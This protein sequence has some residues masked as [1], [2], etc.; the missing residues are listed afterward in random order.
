[1]NNKRRQPWRHLKRCGSV[2]QPT[3][4]TFTTRTRATK[5]ERSPKEL[6]LKTCRMTGSARYAGL[7]KRI[8]DPWAD[9]DPWQRKGTDETECV[10][11]V[12]GRIDE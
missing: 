9:P 11:E 7:R 8:L 12:K 2:R 4:D 1:M 3:A 5:R 10:R 6:V